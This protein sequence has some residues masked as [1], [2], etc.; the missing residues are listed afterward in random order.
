LQVAS[1]GDC[2]GETVAESRATFERFEAEINRERREL[3][4]DDVDGGS[5]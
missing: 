2:L 4:G 5:V 1:I 3:G